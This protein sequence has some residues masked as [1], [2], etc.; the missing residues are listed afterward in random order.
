MPSSLHLCSHRSSC[1]FVQASLDKGRGRSL[2]EVSD[3]YCPDF[4]TQRLHLRLQYVS[5]GTVLGGTVCHNPANRGGTGPNT[6]LCDLDSEHPELLLRS[7]GKGMVILAF[8]P[9]QAVPDV[10]IE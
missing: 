10:S 2:L 5:E 7:L 4:W 8:R 6:S 9:H 1:L 3:D